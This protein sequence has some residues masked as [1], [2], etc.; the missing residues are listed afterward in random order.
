[1]HAGSAN[2]DNTTWHKP[3]ILSNVHHILEEDAKRTAPEAAGEIETVY[4]GLNILAN[5]AI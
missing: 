2:T 4:S 5:S 3:S 1:M